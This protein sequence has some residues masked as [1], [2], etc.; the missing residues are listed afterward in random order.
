[1]A[2]LPGIE[3][4][5]V[6]WPEAGEFFTR[7]GVERLTRQFD[8]LV[9]YDMPGI[10]F[11]RGE[12]PQLLPPSREITDAWSEILERGLPVLSMHHSL[13]SWPTWEGFAEIVKGRFHYVPATLRG[14][15]YPDSGYAMKVHQTFSVVE[16]DHPV[17]DGLPDRFELEDETYQCPVFDDEVTVLISTDAPRDDTFHAS[18]L[19]AVRRESG[20]EWHHAPTSAAVA[21][22][23]TKGR[24]TIVYLQPGD[25]PEAFGNAHYR[26]LIANAIKWLASMKPDLTREQ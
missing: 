23:H 2:D 11:N 17:C 5:L 20:K 15:Q 1:M 26:H 3:S 10:R 16:K 25:G 19:A 13:A 8:V 14:A 7:E 9:L 22:T 4:S 18:A 12:T 6:E 24:S 21:W